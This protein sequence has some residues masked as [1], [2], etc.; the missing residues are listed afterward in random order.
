[1]PGCPRELCVRRVQKENGLS[2]T[3]TETVS[4]TTLESALPFRW[5]LWF[6]LTNPFT[7]LF[8]GYW[9]MG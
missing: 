7:Y 1:M 4:L 9:R 6:V 2:Y 8:F 3:Y 5:R